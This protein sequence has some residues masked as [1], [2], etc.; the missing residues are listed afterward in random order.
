[1]FSTL[2]SQGIRSDI[3]WGI[4]TIHPDG[5]N[6]DPLVSA[7]DPG[8]APNGF[9]FQTQLSDGC[10]VVEEY[11]NQNNSGFG[12]YFKLPPQ[13]PDGYPAF[14]PAYMNDPRNPP[15]ALRPASTTARRKYY[16]MPFM[17]DGIGVAHA[18]RARTAKARPIRPSSATRTRRAVGKFTHPSGAPDNHLL[19][20]YSPGPVNHQYTYL[21]QLDGGIYLIKDGEPVDEPAQMLLIKNDPNYNE[22]WPR[23]VVPYKRIYGI[24]EPKRL[25]PLANDGK[26]SQHLP[27]GTPFGLVG[28]SSLY[29]RES[30]PN[31]GVPEGK[32]TATYAGGN[33]PWKG[34]DAF[35]SHGNGMPLNWHNQGADAGLYTNDDIHAVRILAMEP[36]TDR[37]RGAKQRPAVLQPRQR[38]AAHPRRDSACASSTDGKQPLDPDGNPDTSFLAKIPA[39]VAV[40]VPDARQATAW[41]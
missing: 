12:T 10:I 39:D 17:P 34:L 29:K 4:W 9:H 14:G 27:E 30:Y 16:R 2:E 23:A 15:L 40:H 25:A 21:P 24:D 7:F 33:D 13:P 1:M 28:T 5:T 11:Y 22:S 18:V 41:C 26:L 19:T 6:W 31:G 37:N 20:V 35:T 8:G 38:T 3:L 36:T 32:V